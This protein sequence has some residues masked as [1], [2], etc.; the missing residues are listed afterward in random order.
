MGRAKAGVDWCEYCDVYPRHPC[1]DKEEAFECP[2]CPHW[3]REYIR[4]TLPGYSRS[5]ADEL[6]EYRRRYGRL[7]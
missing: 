1:Q 6:A 2:N 7:K 4:E 5:E 3:Q